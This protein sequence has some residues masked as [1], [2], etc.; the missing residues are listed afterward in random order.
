MKKILLVS[1]LG[2]IP[3]VLLASAAFVFA[4]CAISAECFAICTYRNSSGA[5]FMGISSSG[6]DSACS[7]ASSKCTG[8]GCTRVSCSA[9][10]C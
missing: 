2:M 8:S 7:E 4:P 10:N 9:T 3:A 5:R 1:L 6:C